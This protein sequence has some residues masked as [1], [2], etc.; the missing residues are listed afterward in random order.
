MYTLWAFRFTG[1]GLQGRFNER[2]ELYRYNEAK[3][4][5]ERLISRVQQAL[6]RLGICIYM[7][8]CVAKEQRRFSRVI[9]IY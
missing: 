2:L 1:V 6:P 5:K 4:E 8:V 7:C 9:H 3:K